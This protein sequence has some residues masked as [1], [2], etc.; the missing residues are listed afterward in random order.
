M[1]RRSIFGKGVRTMKTSLSLP[2]DLWRA[3]KIRAVN[4]KRNLQDLI[5]DALREYLKTKGKEPKK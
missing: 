5:A 2:E 4:E 1:G 3:A